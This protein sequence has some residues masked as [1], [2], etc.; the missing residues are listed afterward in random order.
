MNLLMMYFLDIYNFFCMC[1]AWASTTHDHRSV[2]L[3]AGPG[4]AFII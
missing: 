4:L 3:R 1:R 2:V